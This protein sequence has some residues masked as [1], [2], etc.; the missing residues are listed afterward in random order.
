MCVC[1]RFECVYTFSTGVLLLFPR[2]SE[3]NFW[4]GGP[5]TVVPLFT[6]RPC[7]GCE[8]PVKKKRWCSKKRIQQETSVQ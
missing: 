1:M 4:I 3:H 6:G 8:R 7:G 5:F 2:F